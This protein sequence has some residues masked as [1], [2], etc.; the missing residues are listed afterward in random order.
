MVLASARLR[1]IHPPDNIQNG[2]RPGGE[3]LSNA[4]WLGPWRQHFDDESWRGSVTRVDLLCTLFCAQ[5]LQTSPSPLP[6]AFPNSLLAASSPVFARSSLVAGVRLK[7][8]VLIGLAVH[9]L[10]YILLIF[11]FDLYRGA[12]GGGSS[13]SSNTTARLYKLIEMR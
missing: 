9:A 7:A 11:K 4:H 1:G 2:G 8:C 13:I 12:C 3:C 10:I 6:V 5:V